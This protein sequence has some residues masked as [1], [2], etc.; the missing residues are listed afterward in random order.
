MLAMT[1]FLSLHLSTAEA[2]SAEAQAA[3]E[4]LFREGRRL[5]DEGHVAQACRKFEA[6]YQM[7]VALGTLLN[8]ASCLEQE[9]R[10]ASA[11]ARFIEA[12]TRSR[13]AG[14]PERE[15]VAHARAA[16]LESRLV[17]LRLIVPDPVD[18]MVVEVGDREFGPAL[19]NTPIPI[20]PGEV[21]I[22]ATAPG[23]LRWTHSVPA[24][25]EG[26]TV[27][28][29]VPALEP[30]P[31]E[32]EPVELTPAAEPIPLVEAE[33]AES[34]RS[35]RR[36]AG[37]TIGGVGV[38][39][40]AVSL[41]LT[42]N[43]RSLW[44]FADCVDGICMSAQDQADAETARTRANVATGMVVTGGALVATAIIVLVTGRGDDE[45]DDRVS[46]LRITPVA[47]ANGAGV[48]IGGSF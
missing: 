20:D 4:A 8:L 2:Q 40:L 3:A 12:E 28:V 22:T 19:W 17:R 13:R 26:S 32:E 14:S 23:Y 44:K 31:I 45:E 42:R 1:T 15:R 41:G 48:S 47:D 25:E 21:T 43:A 11:W 29:E 35:A 37:Y 24:Q 5:L 9:G 36:I 39:A 30:A 33:P 34:P 38:A 18:G 27:E 16:A 10:L 46:R 7:D 6:S